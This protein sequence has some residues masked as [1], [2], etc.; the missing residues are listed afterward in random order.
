VSAPGRRGTYPRQ[1]W[2]R[3]GRPARRQAYLLAG[4]LAAAAAVAGGAEGLGAEQAGS[5]P[6]LPQVP[7]ELS[8]E[9][10]V[11]L[12]MQQ[13][14][15]LKLERRSVERSS[16]ALREARA[17]L[18]PKL[19]FRAAAAYLTNPPEGISLAAGSLPITIDQPPFPLVTV[20]FP[21][22]ELVL[23]EDP[24]PTYFELSL[25][26][27][28]PVF[29]WLKLKNAVDLAGLGVEVSVAEM[30]EARRWI[31]RETAESYYAALLARESRAHLA[32]MVTVFG[33]IEADRSEAYDLGLI[34][35]RELLDARAQAAEA[36]HSL[37]EA[38]EGLLTALQALEF[39]TGLA[40]EAPELSSDFATAGTGPEEEILKR[41]S[42]H[43]SPALKKAR[44]QLEQARKNAAR[45]RGA[46]ILKPDF[47][48]SV[49]VDVSG[50]KPPWAGEGWEG[51]WDA[52]VTIGLG[53]EG[54]LFDS[55]RSRWAVAQAEES[56]RSAE[57]ALQLGTRQIE[58]AVRRAVQ[59]A[60]VAQ[61]R[62]AA[63]EALLRAGR[64]AEANAEVGF[65]Q[66]LLTRE[67]L[68][69]ARLE[70]LLGEIELLRARHAAAVAAVR[71]EYLAGE[72][73]QAL[74]P[75]G[76]WAR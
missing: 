63:A 43:R 44:L 3:G 35:L 21:E 51:S 14:G 57:E 52:N 32:G 45:L 76:W 27:K 13:A 72:S 28:Q 70:R 20:P 68:G 30:E 42:L 54:S 66:E 33:E 12:A 31:R 65:T 47:A 73:P 56:A 75:T 40:V 58:L 37:L 39:Y 59:E 5:A 25:E 26:L 9:Q 34:N 64:A 49:A 24:E 11:S 15:A 60:R 4:L 23:L 61:G 22:E 2:R 53:A 55:G 8:L 46:G 16:L 48:L 10:A 38:E 18:G 6:V 7:R 29:T 71:L 74:G 62:I 41:Q 19:T 69:G 67:Q 17:A 1:A 36:G 50:Q